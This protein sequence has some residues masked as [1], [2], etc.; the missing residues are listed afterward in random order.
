MNF[1]ITTWLNA[2]GRTLRATSLSRIRY[3]LY[4]HPSAVA[5]SM[6]GDAFRNGGFLCTVCLPVNMR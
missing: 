1:R 5:S 3:S 2:N 6:S 4:T